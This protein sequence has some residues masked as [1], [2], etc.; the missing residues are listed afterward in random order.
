MEIDFS[1]CDYNSPNR[2]LS[3]YFMSCFSYHILS[4]LNLIYLK[5]LCFSP[6]PFWDLVWG[7]VSN[8]S[9]QCN[10]FSCNWNKEH[11]SLEVCPHRRAANFNCFRSADGLISGMSPPPLWWRSTPNAHCFSLADEPWGVSTYG[12]KSGVAGGG[13]EGL[14][15]APIFPREGLSM[16]HS[17]CP[18]EDLSFYYFLLPPGSL[19]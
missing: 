10:I 5:Y 15:V 9:P 6:A 17:R 14:E 19:K 13:G 2:I 16:L 7:A 8:C 11:P 3:W 4:Y 18:T 1:F 12:P